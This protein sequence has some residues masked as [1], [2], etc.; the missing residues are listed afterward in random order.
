M[1]KKVERNKPPRY[2]KS[3]AEKL[4]LGKIWHFIWEDNSALSWV[5]NVVLAFILIKFIIY[6]LLGLLLGSQLPVVAVI[7]ESMTHAPTPICTERSIL[8]GRCLAHESEVR[9]ICGEN[10]LG[11]GHL[12]L[13]GY[14]IKC[15]DWYE[16]K[17]ITKEQFATFP[18]KKG[19]DKGDV[20]VLRGAKPETL[21]VGDILIYNSNLDENYARPYPIIHRIV[22]IRETPSGYI[23]E[24]KGD[25]NEFQITTSVFDETNITQA[26]IIGKGAL[27]I[28][29]IGYVK[30]GFVE[31][32][33]AI[34][35]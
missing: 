18:F 26:Q 23:Y 6:P 7:S 31:L 24:T 35:F 21:E 12:N 28:P 22:A 1:P 8:D 32:L 19:F 14:W 2:K 11:K 15:G 17:N 27:R 5:A 3:Y 16:E 34:G 29:W 33:Q 9:E 25:H 10:L 20:I 13:D 4:T 30:I